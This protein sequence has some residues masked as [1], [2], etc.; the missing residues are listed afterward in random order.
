[1]T[2]P[3]TLSPD[4]LDELARRE[5]ELVVVGQRCVYLDDYRI[6]GSKPYVSENLPQHS[7]KIKVQ[8]VLNA[9]PEL[10]AALRAQAQGGSK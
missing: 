5:I 7:F 1:M 8:D 3:N 10:S 4:E 9:L 6:A 2:M